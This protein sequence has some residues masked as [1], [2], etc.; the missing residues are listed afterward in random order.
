VTIRRSET[1]EVGHRFNI[2]YEQVWHVTWYI[3]G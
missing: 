3:A 1:C 2:P